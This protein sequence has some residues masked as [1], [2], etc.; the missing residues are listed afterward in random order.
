MPQVDILAPDF[1]KFLKL[2]TVG[3][4]SKNDIPDYNSVYLATEQGEYGDEPGQ[5]TLLCGYS[6]SFDQ[7]MTSYMPCDG[8]LQNSVISIPLESAKT[9]I[10]VFTK[11]AKRFSEDENY[12]LT[13]SYDG[14][15]EMLSVGERFGGGMPGDPI[16]ALQIPGCVDGLG[17]VTA[18]K[19]MLSGQGARTEVTT[20]DG[21]QIAPGNSVVLAPS[22][23]QFLSA[24]GRNTKCEVTLYTVAH[25]WSTHLFQSGVPGYQPFCRGAI[26][27]TIADEDKGDEPDMELI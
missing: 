23:L 9:L 2:L 14:E 10:S 17:V 16:F 22:T 18:A 20:G 4:Y 11:R 13:L 6:L 24:V 26:V 27:P 25:P 7:C 12:S 5:Q 15:N 19:D 8:D 3:A 1:L 21:V